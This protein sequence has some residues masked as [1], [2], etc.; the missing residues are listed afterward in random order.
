MGWIQ[1]VGAQSNSLVTTTGAFDEADRADIKRQLDA[2]S[3]ELHKSKPYFE[4]SV[5]WYF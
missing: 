5:S 4:G 3:D 2:E 1:Y